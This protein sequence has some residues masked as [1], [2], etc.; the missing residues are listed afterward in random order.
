MSCRRPRYPS[1]LEVD[2][3]LNAGRFKATDYR[4]PYE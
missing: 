3:D 1:K 2:Y 4:Q